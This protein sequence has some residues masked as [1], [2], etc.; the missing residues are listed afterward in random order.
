MLKRLALAAFILVGFTGAAFAQNQQPQPPP[1]RPEMNPGAP[2]YDTTGYQTKLWRQS[3]TDNPQSDV[4]PDQLRRARRAVALI[5]ANHCED[6][7]NMALAEHDER[8]A[9][10][11]AVACKARLIE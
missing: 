2:R 11:I 9:L 5:K 8:L 3:M 7:Y 1:Q 10:N 6:A 4:T